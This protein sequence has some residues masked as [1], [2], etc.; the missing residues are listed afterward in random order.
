M[1]KVINK[2]RWKAFPTLSESW[3]F[4]VYDPKKTEKKIQS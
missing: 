1:Y 2:I 3:E 4:Y